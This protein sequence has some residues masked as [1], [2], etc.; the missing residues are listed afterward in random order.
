MYTARQEDTTIVTG[1]MPIVNSDLSVCCWLRVE[2]AG[3]PL[4][5]RPKMA[6]NP[7]SPPNV[8]ELRLDFLTNFL[9]VHATCME[10]TAL[11]WVDRTGYISFKNDAFFLDRRIRNGYSREQRFCIGM[12]RMLVEILIGSQFDNLA[13]VHHR[14][15]VADMLYDVQIMGN[16]EIG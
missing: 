9:F 16:K 4:P 1:A 13:E 11:G 2:P 8:L 10:M 3:L 5:C 14:D 7:V 12:L 15:P 6:G